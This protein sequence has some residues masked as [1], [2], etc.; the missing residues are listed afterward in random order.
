MTALVSII[1]VNWNSRDDLKECLE[2]FFKKVKYPNYEIILVDNASKDDSVNYVKKNYPKIT[3]VQSE[4]NLGFAGG[5]NLG[6]KKCNG[7][8]VLFLN[9]DTITT[10]DFLAP[11]VKFMEEREDVGIVQPKILFHRPG[12]S[13]HHKVNSVG[14][15]LLDTGFLYHLDYG[16]S[17]KSTTYP[18]EIF[19]AYGACFLARKKVIDR[20]GLFDTTYFAYFEETDLCH[21][22]WLAGWKIMAITNALIYHKGAKTAKRLPTAFIQYHSFKNR[23]F[24]YLKNLDNVNLVKIFI[25]HLIICEISSVIY[26]LTGKPDYTLAIQ[27]AILW[28]FINFNRLRK[29]RKKVQEVIRKVDDS[30]FIPKLTKKVN[31][32]YYYY[33]SSGNLQSYKE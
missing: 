26:L 21:R 13:L 29:E 17:V 10:E 19:S 31:L 22:V 32:N 9:N 18:Y 4:S 20:V 27:K 2:S 14:S 3:I 11:L 15:F 12:T 28:N 7:K 30:E 1:I 5:N 24:T 8:Y 16:K 25:P 33:L 23:I 6:F